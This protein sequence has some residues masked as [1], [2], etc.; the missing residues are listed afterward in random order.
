MEAT[1]SAFYQ[2]SPSGHT[3]AAI[4]PLRGVH[5]VSA[6][7]VPMPEGAAT[8]F[9]TD[10]TRLDPDGGILRLDVYS[11]YPIS[12]GEAAYLQAEF[13][14]EMVS[15]A[16]RDVL[17]DRSWRWGAAVGLLDL[18]VLVGLL[19]FA[20]AN[21]DRPF[22]ILAWAFV[23]ALAPGPFMAVRLIMRRRRSARARR[24]ARAGFV[25]AGSGQG[26]AGSAYVKGIW[27]GLEQAGGDRD[28][29]TLERICAVNNWAAGVRFYRSRRAR[30]P[31]GPHV[32]PG[33][34]RLLDRLS[35]GR[36]P[37]YVPGVLSRA[38]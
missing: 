34:R 11:P 23:L 24:L 28:L 9:D 30:R 14:A 38:R 25:G 26:G 36:R 29:M 17:R 12:D 27:D 5:R 35:G 22:P 19:L 37:H 1:I 18:I 15:Y 7:V 13:E 4:D 2:N 8:F 33:R 20:L 6:Y 10:L 16:N 32:R 21:A 3:P 31:G